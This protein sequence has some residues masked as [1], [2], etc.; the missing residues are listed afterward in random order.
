MG[1]AWWTVKQNKPSARNWAIVASII[2]C[3]IGLGLS[4][5]E[6][7]LMQ[8]VQTR[9][10]HIPPGGLLEFGILNL[11]FL[12]VGV[13]GLIAFSRHDA[14]SEPA[15]PKKAPRIAG[16]GTSSVFDFIAIGL[17]IIGYLVGQNLWYRWALK[18][19][20]P[21]VRGGM[22]WPI[23]LAAILL[24]VLLHEIGHASIGLLLGMKL[25]AFIVGPFQFRV[26]DGRW[27]FKFLPTKI[28]SGGGAAALVSG[29]PSQ[30]QWCEICMIAAGPIFS[31][32]TGLAAS[33]LTQSVVGTEYEKDWQFLALL[34]TFGFVSFAVNLL[35]LR[36]EANYSDGARIYQLLSGGPWVDLHRA[37]A[38]P[39]SSTVTSLRP[40]NYDIGAIEKAS[41]WLT[42]GHRAF[43]LRLFAVS[44]L[45]DS[46][47][48][49]DALLPL[50]EAERIY[51]ESAS[52][53][54][55]ELHTSLV[56][57]TA[58]LRRDPVA[59][60]KWWD[61]M[62]AKKPTH[63]GVDYWLAKS[64]LCWIEGRI[65]EANLAW[66]KGAALADKLPSAGCYEFDRSRYIELNK[67]IVGKVRGSFTTQFAEA[68]PS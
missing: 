52:D 37:L 39:A 51:H 19:H 40:R 26:R 50:A 63:L 22:Y 5:S 31:L 6:L 16:D 32:M 58:F 38:I 56:F 14:K 20:L 13:A 45:F 53:I 41:A 30:P 28:L 47:R 44:Y 33:V 1:M 27:R 29:D 9:G 43:L 60:R 10:L 34:S 7:L 24:D 35:P 46:G 15:F 2:S 12:G 62:E 11:A 8:R 18:H 55:A 4:V 59:A 42:T 48:Q 66:T 57:D 21:L 61:L 54:P 23:L 25:R 36:P 68:V 49:A 3:L 17:G 65:D 67:E 64:A